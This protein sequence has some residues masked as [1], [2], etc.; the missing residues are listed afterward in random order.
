MSFEWKT[1]EVLIRENHVDSLG[2]MNNATYLQIF[3]EA[4][5]EILTQRNYGFKKIQQSQQGPVILDVTVKFLKE[6]KLRDKITITTELLD[7]QGKVGHLKQKMVKEDGTVASEAVFSFGLFD[8]KM[9]KLI[10][11]SDEWKYAVGAL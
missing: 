5:W 4:R 11:P 2:H 7:Y 1:Y 8:L 6:I 9:R 3:E 10:E